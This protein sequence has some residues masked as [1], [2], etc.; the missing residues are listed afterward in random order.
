MSL[1]LPDVWSWNQ[2]VELASLIPKQQSLLDRADDE[3][4]AALDVASAT[5]YFF[6]L[7]EVEKRDERAIQ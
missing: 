4:V 3:T 6:I 1:T 7:A 5:L 2:L